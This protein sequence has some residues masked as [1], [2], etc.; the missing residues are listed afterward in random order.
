MINLVMNMNVIS[1]GIGKS[2]LLEFG[3][4]VFAN[5]KYVQIVKQNKKYNFLH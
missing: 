5:I 3:I 1:V 4:V 2:N